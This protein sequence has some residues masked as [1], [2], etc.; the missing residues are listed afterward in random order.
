MNKLDVDKY[1]KLSYKELKET[2]LTLNCLTLY[3]K[4]P[5]HIDS[6]S[7]REKTVGNMAIEIKIKI[8]EYLINRYKIENKYSSEIIEE[9]DNM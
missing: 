2:L 7:E 8:L 4:Y 6:M 3:I 9:F 5:E 1:C